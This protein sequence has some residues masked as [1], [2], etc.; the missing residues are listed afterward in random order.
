MP[1]TMYFLGNAKTVTKINHVPCQTVQY[2][3]KG[4]LPAQLMD[5][6]PIQVSLIIEQHLPF[7]HLVLVTNTQY[8]INIQRPKVPHPSTQEVEQLSPTF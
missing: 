4:M 7:S 3:E 2:D 8:Y 5:D 1:H 6:T